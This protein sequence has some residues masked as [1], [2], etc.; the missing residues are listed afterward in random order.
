[1]SRTIPELTA[2]A[3]T[4]FSGLTAD[5]NIDLDLPEITLPTDFPLPPE[6]GGAYEPL[7][8][9]T[10]ANLTTASAD[11]S[12]VFDVLMRAVN[13]QLAEQHRLNRITGADY[14]KVYLGSITSVLQFG[15]Q[16]LLSKDQ[17]MLQNLQLQE[18]VKLAA[19]QRVRAAADVQI[20][21]G[22]IVQIS[23]ENAKIKLDAN[24]SANEYAIS[25]VG[26]VTAYDQGLINEANISLTK[27]QIEVQRA[28]TWDT[29]VN[30]TPILGLAGK[31][32]ELI[33]AQIQTQ[34]EELDTARASTKDTLLGGGPVLGLVAIDKA[35][36]EAQQLEMENRGLLTLQQVEATRAQV[37]DTLSDGVTPV[38]GILAEEKILKQAQANLTNEQYEA[39]RAQTRDTLSDG[40]AITGLVG[41]EKQIKLAQKLL[42]E[43]QVDTQ[44][45]QTKNTLTTGG[46]I[47]GIAEQE[48][49]LKTAQAKYINE[50]YESQRGQ[51]RNTLSTG[52]TLAGIMG[53]QKALYEE[54]I[55]SYKRDAE[56]KAVKMMLDTWTARKTIDDGTPLPNGIDTAAIDSALGSF[57]ANLNI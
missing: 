44:R 9:I 37:A 11:G 50:Q 1:M 21:R 57:R 35:F 15:T 26:L 52:E 47:I 24:T 39:A 4:L 25:K 12:G 5:L 16:F 8:P 17:S 54:Q 38:A 22:Q 56:S 53:V 55:T 23:Y 46:P 3:N 42:T 40:G 27:E 7:D 31:Q 34:L 48:R 51:T 20:A 14:A 32:K 41:V 28:Q 18:Q 43:E 36:K 33:D 13:G 30:G 19:L 6:T 45:A 2:D 29:H 10:V 49:L